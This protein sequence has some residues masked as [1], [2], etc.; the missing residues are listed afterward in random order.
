MHEKEIKM[1]NNETT[2]TTNGR[3]V[4]AK[5]LGSVIVFLLGSIGT[6]LF[7]QS[8]NTNNALRN[9]EQLCGHPIITERVNN[10]QYNLE[11][12]ENKLNEIDKKLDEPI[13][14]LPAK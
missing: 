13:I 4:T 3:N 1:A 8:L 10:L 2:L 9:H 6:L 11:K 12:I 14:I 5:I 7:A